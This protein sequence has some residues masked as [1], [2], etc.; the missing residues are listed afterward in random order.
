PVYGGPIVVEPP[1]G[2]DPNPTVVDSGPRVGGVGY[3]PYSGQTTIGVNRYRERA[4][5]YDPG[6]GFVDPGSYRVVDRI[7]T[8]EFGQQFRES[9]PQWTAG[10]RPHGDLTRE[11]V[12]GTGVPGV[13]VYETDRI[14]YSQRG[15]PSNQPAAGSAP[16]NSRPSFKPNQPAAS[17]SRAPAP[18]AP[19]NSKRPTQKA[20]GGGPQKAPSDRR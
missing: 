1:I 18:N 20:S 13:N 14:K 7:V 15:K 3:D 19:S 9:G 17:P 8:D 5:A 4:S 11:R 10:G 16:T 2:F 12:V 6:R